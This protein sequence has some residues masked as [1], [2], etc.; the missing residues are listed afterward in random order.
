MKKE[1]FIGLY[2]TAARI[3]ILE[4]ALEMNKHVA[5]YKNS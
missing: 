2:I 3:Q 4:V 5:K 1:C